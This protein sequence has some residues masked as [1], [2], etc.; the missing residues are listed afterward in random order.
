MTVAVSDG[1]APSLSVAVV[2]GVLVP[3]DVC[4]LEGL[5]PKDRVAEG[6]TVAVWLGDDPNDAVPDAVAV[7]DGTAPTVSEPVVLGVGV[8]LCVPVPVGDGVA[9]VD[10]VDVGDAETVCDDVMDAEEPH[11]ALVVAVPLALPVPLGVPV[12]LRVLVLVASGVL[13]MLPVTLPVGVPLAPKLLVDV[14]VRLPGSL[15]L[16]LG[17]AESES[18]VADG[19]TEGDVPKLSEPDGVVLAV[20]TEPVGVDVAERGRRMGVSDRDMLIVGDD[21]GV[22]ESEP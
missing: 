12:W 17:V 2:L 1:S 13:V 3:L 9:P 20:N 8:P 5:A 4:E 19:V 7:D 11:V 6:D 15:A 18:S 22:L 10:S 16:T 14:G 21:V